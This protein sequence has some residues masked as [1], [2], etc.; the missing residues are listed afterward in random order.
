MMKKWTAKMLLFSII[1]ILAFLSGC[2]SSET[3]NGST[4][5]K[6]IKIGVTG[7]PPEEITNIVKEVAK[8]EGINLELITFNDYLTP[9]KALADEELDL[10]MFQTIQFLG[11]YVEDRKD[12]IMPIGSTYNSTIGIY[13]EKYKS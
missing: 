1:T 2:S 9:N 3:S 6:T 12:P 4:K 5:E 7:G 11:Q 8:G 13:S 10:N